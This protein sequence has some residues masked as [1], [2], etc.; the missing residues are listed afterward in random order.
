M[1]RQNAF[2][3]AL[4]NLETRETPALTAYVSSGYLYVLGTSGADFIQVQQSGDQVSVRNAT[5]KYNGT[6]V[7]SIS[8]SKFNKVAVYAY[9]GNDTVVL[10]P[11]GSTSLLKD[12]Y[13]YGGE[14]NDYIYGGKGKDYLDGGNG[15]DN[16]FGNDGD[17]YLI[18][19]TNQ[20]NNNDTLTGGNGF[21]WYFRG[22]NLNQPVV[23]GMKVSDVVQGR[24]PTCQTMAALAEAVRQGVDFTQDIKYLGNSTYNI[25]LRGGSTQA[26]NFNGWY[27]DN[28][29]FP[30]NGTYEFWTILMS[31][32]RLQQLGVSWVYA[33]SNA[34][35]DWIH[36]NTTKG[37]LY[38]IGHALYTF[39]G[40]S[41]PYYT[42]DTANAQSM[43]A[44]LAR[45]DMIVGVSAAG[46]GTTAAGISRYHA[47]AVMA[48]YNEGG[49]WK[50]RLYNPWGTDR[51]N[52]GT[53]D[54]LRSGTTA[55]NDGFL[56]LTWSQF[57]STSNFRGFC[58]AKVST[59][60][61]ASYSAS[62]AYSREA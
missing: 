62:A 40:I 34:D 1:T 56:T 44:S 59:A 4:E 24:S 23:N 17:D 12:A 60:Q 8:A 2:K 47:Y 29:P 26:V 48:V 50:V 19:G 10:A 57:V 51:D 7:S 13:V 11:S 46:S 38:S 43:Q 22:F 31:R 9:A 20:S 37:K 25:R 39:T 54:S 27:N 5:I 18:G 52:G 41:T 30:A 55:K 15:S 33:Y 21:D 3:P 53:I 58:I 42:I 35:W 28:D 14:G 61:A 49:T 32:A 36:N 6:N 16:I 45:G